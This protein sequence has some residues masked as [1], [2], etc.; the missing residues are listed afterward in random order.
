MSEELTA[1]TGLAV[2][3]TDEAK[4]VLAMLL[5]EEMA[6]LVV[7]GAA[8]EGLAGATLLVAEAFSGVTETVMTLVTVLV[9]TAVSSTVLVPTRASFMAPVPVGRMQYRWW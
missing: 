2:D 1:S 5:G 8:E 3:E 6:A 7:A 9:T 4:T